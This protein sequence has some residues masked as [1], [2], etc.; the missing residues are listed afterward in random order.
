MEIHRLRTVMPVV[1]PLVLAT[2]LPHRAWA[3]NQPIVASE[4]V[5]TAQRRAERQLD[6]PITV[7]TISQEALKAA[8]M[9]NLSDITKMAP[10]VRF[11]YAS[12]FYQPT[13][14]GVGT[15]ITTAGGGSNVGIYIDG[16][17]SPNSLA[18]DFQLTRIQSIQV[19]KGPQ[20]TLFG[21]NT[22]GGAILVQTADPST[23]TSAE[24]R[25]SYGRFHEFKGQGY[26]TFGLTRDI[27]LDIEGIYSKGH[28]YLTNISDNQRVGDYETWTIRTGLKWQITD[29]FSALLRYQHNKL[30]DPTPTLTASYTESSPSY[31]GLNFVIHSGAPFYALPSEQTFDK[32][33][34]ASGSNPS[35]QEFFREKGDTIQLTLKGDLGFADVVSYSQ[36]RKEKVDSSIEIDYS[37]NP[38]TQLGLPNDNKTWS[39]EVLFT[40]KPGTKLQWTAGGFLFSN[41]DTYIVFLDY[42]PAIGVTNRHSFP[43]FGS[44]A[45]VHTAAIFLDATYEVTPQLFITAGARYSHDWDTNAWTQALFGPVVYAT[46]AQYDEVKANHI[47]PRV[48]VRYKPTDYTSVYASYTKGYKVGIFDLGSGAVIPVAPE[49]IDAFETGFKYDNHRISFDLSAFYYNYKNLQVSIFTTASTATIINAAKSKIYGLDGQFHARVTENFDVSVSAAYTDAKYKSFLGAP[50]YTP[51]ATLP[52]GCTG[53]SFPAVRKD[54]NNV[55]MQR[56]PKFT[57]N[58]NARY[59]T[60]KSNIGQFVFSGNFFYSSKLY[61][62]PSGIQF[63]QKSYGVL[64][65]RAQWND[66]SDHYTVAIYGDNVTDTRYKTQVQYGQTGIGTNWS[67]P[68]TYGVEVGFKY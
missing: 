68:V 27:A 6:V 38:T 53:L 54:L 52:G 25:A 16:F 15:A 67:K 44:S 18:N 40:S 34:I 47:T 12:G 26:A 20:G 1:G 65:L 9:Q 21:R 10:A 3:Q 17:Y 30:D 4:V 14:R 29:K 57:G 64:S 51:C 23:T 35:D 56:A 60:D 7:N 24:G 43:Q 59:A 2:L 37:G 22:T 61:F 33:Q 13:I 5:V 41:R 45:T 11:D 63:P 66:P 36:F 42:A 32:N 49:S 28:G 31:P 50:I 58:I 48:V 19:L 55:P 62:G 8:N 46:K 39:Q